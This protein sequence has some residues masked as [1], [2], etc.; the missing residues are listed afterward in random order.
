MIFLGC[1]RNHRARELDVTN[2]FGR[3][4]WRARR[5]ILI[6]S[7]LTK[8][9]NVWLMGRLVN[10]SEI[11]YDEITV[12]RCLPNDSCDVFC[13]WSD[14]SINSGKTDVSY[15]CCGNFMTEVKSCE[16]ESL[17]SSQ[18]D[19]RKR[20]YPSHSKTNRGPEFSF[21]LA[22]KSLKSCCGPRD[23]FQF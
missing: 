17:I 11:P 20:Y 14:R 22:T 4:Q 7:K 12:A 1:Y 21:W 2:L 10:S 23:F 15:W 8:T 3:L 9:V 5:N 18:H 19:H 6:T 16:V 13:V